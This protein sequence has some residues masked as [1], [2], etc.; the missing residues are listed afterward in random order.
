MSIAEVK[1]KLKLEYLILPVISILIVTLVSIDIKAGLFLVLGIFSLVFLYK[2]EWAIYAIIITLFFEAYVFSFYLLGAR[3]RAVQ[4]VEVIAIVN[5]LIAILIGKTKLKKTPIDFLLWAYILIN[6]VALINAPSVGRSLK[7]A[8][9][10]LSLALLYYVIVNFITERT[11]FDKAFNLLLYIGLA[12]ILYGLYQV[13]AGMCNCYLNINLP[14]GHA[15]IVHREF[16]GSPWGRPYGTLVEPDWYG[17]IAMFYALLFISLYFSRLTE[18]KNFYLF[19]MVISTIGMLLS[20]VRASWVGFLVGLLFLSIL[21][22][23][24]KLS[25][26]RFHS[27]VKILSLL[28][29]L[30]LVLTFLSP[31]FSTIVK[32]RFSTQGEASITTTNV[33]FIQMAHALKLFLRHPIIGNGPGS[34]AIK[35]IWGHIEEH[36]QNLVEEE[37]LNIER[38]YDPNILTT[39][40]EDTGII[41]TILFLLLTL[42]FLIYNLKVVP[43]ISNRYQIISLGLL[44]GIIGLFI[45]YVFTHGFWIPF[46]WVFLGANICALRLGLAEGDR[47]KLA[48]L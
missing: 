38:R 19:G 47:K 40:F 37:K 16:I 32:K 4:I 48:E 24:V 34:F 41:G 11:L 45:S 46:T 14:V 10:L 6:F 7:I 39:V 17:A 20:F 44:A 18:R 8:V 13:F 9:L 42:R 36:Y 31:T 26:I 28:L 29:L 15:G 33:R 27:Y 43:L 30:V 25:K 1:T 21:G 2:K 5:L 35:G 22:H 12:E 3:I 23:K